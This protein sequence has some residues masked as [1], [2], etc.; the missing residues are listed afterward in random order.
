M[1]LIRHRSS[2]LV[3]VLLLVFGI[4]GVVAVG[5]PVAI[6][7][8]DD[9]PDPVPASYYG[10]VEIDGEPAPVGTTVTAEIDGEE[11]GSIVIEE[12][13]R[14]G[15]PT[16][17]D[18]K[19]IV[20]GDADDDGANVTFLV[21]GEPVDTDPDSVT[22]ESASV[23][24]VDL[25]G[26]DID[27]DPVFEV[28]INDDESVTDINTGETAT[29]VATVENTGTVDTEQDVTFEVDGTVEEEITVGLDPDEQETLSFETTLDEAGEFD[30]TVRS[31]DD[32]ASVTLTVTDDDPGA[33]APPPADPDPANLIVTDA[34]L[35]SQQIT[36]GETVDVEATIENVGEE[37]GDTTIELL[38][39]GSVVDSDTVELEGAETETVT[40]TEQFDEPG[41]FVV[42]V[43]DV[44]AGELNVVDTPDPADLSVTA[45]TVTP[46]EIAPGEEITVDATVENVGD[47][48]GELD[49][50]LAI[51]DDI[52]DTQTV[53]VAGDD[54]ADVAFTESLDDEGTYTISVN[55]VD[56]GDVTVATPDDV[57][58]EDDIEE[59]DDDVIPGFGIV[60]AFVAISVAALVASRR[61]SSS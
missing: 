13:G 45:A 35:E 26:E 32:E 25:S 53:S 4:L 52:V 22:W 1:K 29:V 30:A 21:D 3:I 50:E 9:P 60:A 27:V 44:E 14:Y 31:A 54:T 56:A 37:S 7:E 8:D 19:L 43:D 28:T 20:S 47:A 16:I 46:E 17:D 12:E 51:D 55:D 57:E 24:T 38:V 48:E 5:A 59:E 58:D 61:P 11:R 36:V 42:S 40:F 39:D 15:G 18:E 2:G 33:P 10:D 41:T 6:A 34:L 23:E 49:V